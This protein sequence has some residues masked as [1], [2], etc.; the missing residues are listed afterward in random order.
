MTRWIGSAVFSLVLGWASYSMAKPWYLEKAPEG[1]QIA[2]PG[3]GL[4]S[5][6]RACEFLDLEL[7]RRGET[8]IINGPQGK[9]VLSS[10]MGLLSHKGRLLRIKGHPSGRW[11]PWSLAKII[12]VATGLPTKIH[13]ASRTIVA[14]KSASQKGVSPRNKQ[15]AYRVNRIVL[16]PGHGGKDPGAVGKTRFL[17]K[18][19]TLDI[20]LR[21]KKE[22][23]K[24]DPSLEVVLTRSTDVFLKLE[25]RTRIANKQGAD[26]F[27]SIHCNASKSR[28]SSG[29][30]V[31][32]YSP[33]A[34]SQ[35]AAAAVARENAG[36]SPGVQMIL[37][38]LTRDAWKERS[39]NLGVTVLKHVSKGLKLKGRLVRE[40]N[41]YV[42]ALVD[43]PAVL[44]EV[45]YISNP[46]EEKK[47]K[48][49][50]FRK[51]MATLLSRAVLEY[52]DRQGS[53]EP[54]VASRAGSE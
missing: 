36:L 49:T 52:R 39:H 2:L 9:V 41:F 32:T 1:Q 8:F 10:R 25:D 30:E 5:L 4:L 47:L 53:S 51:K 37:A 34:S 48:S 26:L 21:M 31:Y 19:A 13:Q 23:K 35:E 38:S 42:L 16:D 33:R 45:A 14:G 15:N 43:M 28:R 50:V 6:A 17:E 24:M 7:D 54:R 12:S 22:L 3:D 20:A 46:D 18:Q 11:Y 29:S 40:E 44:V 27:V